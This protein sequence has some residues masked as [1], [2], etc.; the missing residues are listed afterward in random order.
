MPEATQELEFI[1]SEAIDPTQQAAREYREA[2]GLASVLSAGAPVQSMWGDRTVTIVSVYPAPLTATF[3]WG[4]LPTY[5]IEPAPKDGASLLHVGGTYQWV[6]DTVNTDSES[7]A[8]APISALGAANSLIQKWVQGALGAGSGL[9][10]GVGIVPDFKRMP[11]R[12]FVNELRD[13]QNRYFQYL[14]QLADSH[15]ARAEFRMIA[16]QHRMAAV[17]IGAVERP[18]FTA[19][20]QEGL[21]ACY[22]CGQ[23]IVIDSIVC[24]HCKQNLPVL[25]YDLG[26][27]PPPEDRAVYAAWTSYKRRKEGESTGSRGAVVRS[28][29]ARSF[30]EAMEENTSDRDDQEPEPE[31]VSVSKSTSK[32]GRK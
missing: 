22:A 29:V 13:K 14:V 19:T 3:N 1:E 25:Y 32:R 4:G 2:G 23:R 8:T 11:T 18:W 30:R 21:K 17:Q 9:S 6:R 20:A 15:F 10:I 28:E 12:E 26:E 27:V 31:P 7:M 16:D 5:R 24:T